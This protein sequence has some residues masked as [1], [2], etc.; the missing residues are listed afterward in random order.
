M[1]VEMILRRTPCSIF[2]LIAGSDRKS[3]RL[4]SSH[5]YTS[6]AVFCLKKKITVAT[7]IQSRVD[8]PFIALLALLALL[9][10]AFSALCL[11]L[12]SVLASGLTLIPVLPM[13]SLVLLA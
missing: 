13:T 6:Y 5:G 2:F 11:R 4:N 10:A 3:T 1:L 8:S 9:P 7:L 12:F